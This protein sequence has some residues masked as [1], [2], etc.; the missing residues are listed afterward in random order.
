MAA[1]FEET[2]AQ[3]KD[4]YVPPE[5]RGKNIVGSKYFDTEG[6]PINREE[7]E[8]NEDMKNDPVWRS[9]RTGET[10][11]ITM[12]DTKLPMD[13]GM[14][15]VLDECKLNLISEEKLAARK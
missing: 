3:L 2:E 13:E 15:K 10:T 8:Q 1:T 6:N 11:R 14:E 4:G 5:D 9:V 12:S 7:I